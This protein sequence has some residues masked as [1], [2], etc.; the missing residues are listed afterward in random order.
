[1]SDAN[2]FTKTRPNPMLNFGLRASIFISGC[3]IRVVKIVAD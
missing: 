2:A 1:M 3:C